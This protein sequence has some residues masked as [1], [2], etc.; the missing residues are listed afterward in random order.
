MD[1]CRDIRR[2][3]DWW[4]RGGDWWAR[5]GGWWPCMQVHGG[6]WWASD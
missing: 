3:G 4:A 1:I 6:G 5:G 2:T